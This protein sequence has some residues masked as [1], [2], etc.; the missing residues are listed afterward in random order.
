MKYA[1]FFVSI[2][3]L[4]LSASLFTSCEAESIEKESSLHEIT[5]QQKYGVDKD[6]ERPGTQGNDN[7]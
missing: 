4:F 1:T 3:F 7:G 5:E 2:L 6:I